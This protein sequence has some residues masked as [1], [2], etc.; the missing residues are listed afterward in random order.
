M[1]LPNG[2]N[3]HWSLDFVLDALS[4][5]RRFR[6]LA[7]VDDFTR[8]CLGLVADTSLSG[9]LAKIPSGI[10]G[11]VGREL[12]RVA[13]RRGCRPAMIVSDNGTEPT[14][15]AIL[16]WQEERGMLCHSI[17]PGGVAQGS[18]GIAAGMVTEGSRST[19]GS[20]RA[21]TD[22]SGTSA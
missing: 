14:P 13:E 2:A 4:S 12:D 1:T 18:C 20:W 9:L 19:T 22:G 8:E 15:H 6:V 5:G 3:Q 17:A 7:V 10:C 21:S 11:W 16:R